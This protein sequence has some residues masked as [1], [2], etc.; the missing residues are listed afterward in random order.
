MVEIKALLCLLKNQF[1]L[2]YT[3]HVKTRASFKQGKTYCSF[4]IHFEKRFLQ[5]LSSDFPVLSEFMEKVERGIEPAELAVKN[6]FCNEDM[7]AN[8]RFIEHNPYSSRAQRLLIEYNVKEILVAAI[9][10][11]SELKDLK[12][13]V[14]LHPSDIEALLKLKLIIE[15]N[16][17]EIPSLHELCRMSG[18]NEDKLKKGFNK[19][20]GTTPYDY[21]IK[22]KM[23][24]AKRLLLDTGLK[25]FEIAYQVGYHHSSNF[26]I[27][28]E[29]LFAY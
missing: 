11:I 17:D 4:D 2:N 27:Q 9:E 13:D 3:P 5:E 15:T 24:E 1:S 25:I 21:H 16:I 6:T 12:R 14:K 20:F 10:R 26:C 8:I 18:L 7:L 28:F 19:L 22:L 29:K 23:E